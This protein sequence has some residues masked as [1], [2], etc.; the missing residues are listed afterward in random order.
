MKC[1]IWPTH[2]ADGKSKPKEMKQLSQSQ[3]YYQP[4]YYFRPDFTAPPII[5]IIY[6]LF[7][8]FLLF[9]VF[10]PHSK[11]GKTKRSGKELTF[12]LAFGIWFSQRLCYLNM[13]EASPQLKF[14]SNHWQFLI[15]LK[16]QICPFH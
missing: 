11:I 12:V 16:S 6:S 5:L 1:L 15:G 8:C 14:H 10:F 7:V 13:K 4:P 3:S 9:G 2:M